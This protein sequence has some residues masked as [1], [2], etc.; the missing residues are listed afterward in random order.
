MYQEL[1]A[2]TQQVLHYFHRHL[3]QLEMNLQLHLTFHHSFWIQKASFKAKRML[4]IVYVKEV[5][6]ETSRLDGSYFIT[7]PEKFSG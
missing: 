5:P 3:G 1:D 6:V 7:S 4:L 2:R